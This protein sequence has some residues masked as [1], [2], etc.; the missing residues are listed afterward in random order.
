MKKVVL[1]KFAK[2]TGKHLY[3]SLFSKSLFFNN[4]YLSSSSNLENNG[5]LQLYSGTAIFMR[6]LRNF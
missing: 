5:S 2:F 3:Q 6:I 4:V 1:K